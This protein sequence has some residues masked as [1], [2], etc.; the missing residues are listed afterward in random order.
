D[1]IRDRNVTGVQTCALPICSSALLR[2]GGQQV[3]E[4]VRGGAAHEGPGAQPGAGGRVAVAHGGQLPGVLLVC[5]AEVLPVSRADAACRAR[6]APRPRTV[7]ALQGGPERDRGAAKGAAGEAV[8]LETGEG[9]AV[10]DA[11]RDREGGV[12][13]GVVP[14]DPAPGVVVEV[15]IGE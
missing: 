8:Q 7:G 11:E 12:P 10:V 1:G 9:V 4:G 3:G 15:D 6:D 13:G 2:T 5:V 14:A